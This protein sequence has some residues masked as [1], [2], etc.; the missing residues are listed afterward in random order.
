MPALSIATVV[1]GAKLERMG[2]FTERT[3]LVSLAQLREEYRRGGLGDEDYE[4][5]PIALFARWIREAQLAQ[6]KEPNAMTLSTVGVTGRPSGRIVLLKE[7][8]ENGFVFYTNYASRKGQ[9]IETNPF[10]G[11]TFYWAE[12]ERQVRVE[13]TARK[14]SKEK[15][16]DY[17][18]TRPKGSR[19]G[20]LVSRQ[21]ETLPSRA[22]LEERLRELERKYAGTDDIPM[23]EYWGGYCVVPEAIEFWQGRTNRLHDRLLYRRNGEASWFAERL[24]P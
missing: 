2:D 18:R 13:G 19:L 24:S 10:V 7:V 16:E 23:P 4:T 17:F 9:E 21:S 22:P 5:N 15:S 20:A 12:L 8:S 14:V 1:G 11:L 3:P 6:L